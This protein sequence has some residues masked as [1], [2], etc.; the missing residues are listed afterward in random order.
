[1]KTKLIAS[2]VAVLLPIAA[3]CYSNTIIFLDVDGVMTS[4]ESGTFFPEDVL[5]YDLNMDNYDVLYA[6]CKT[7]LSTKVVIHSD[8]HNKATM[9]YQGKE[10][11]SLVP[12]LTQLLNFYYIGK[13][14]D[15]PNGSKAMEIRRWVRESGLSLD[16]TDIMYI[17]L[18]DEDTN[19]TNL[20]YMD[21]GKNVRFIH[22]D[23]IRGLTT[24]DFAKVSTK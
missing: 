8:W 9:N 19:H 5:K 1:M 22:V 18:D 6:F 7:N 4:V 3:F 24:K 15:I 16:D 12:T 17:I 14:T 23:K 21:N 13:T 2:I 20:R 11:K 10:Y